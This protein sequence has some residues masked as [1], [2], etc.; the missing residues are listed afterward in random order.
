MFEAPGFCWCC[1]VYSPLESSCIG[2]EGGGTTAPLGI[3]PCYEHVKLHSRE[4]RFQSG[5]LRVSIM[6]TA[7]WPG[8]RVCMRPAPY[9]YWLLAGGARVTGATFWRLPGR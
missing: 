6:S 3:C 5:T 8:L 7:S 4:I 2:R 9:L 1:H